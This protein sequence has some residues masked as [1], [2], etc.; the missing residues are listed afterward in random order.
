LLRCRN[1]KK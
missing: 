1:P